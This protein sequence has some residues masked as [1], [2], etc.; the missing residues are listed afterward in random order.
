MKVYDSVVIG[1]GPAGLSAAIYLGRFNRKVAVIDSCE[2]R[3][4]SREINENYL[5]FPDGIPA[6]ALVFRGRQQ[7]EKFGAEFIESQVD[8]IE[9]QDELFK[10]SLT[11]NEVY[12][13][14][15]VLFAM[16]VEDIWPE[17]EYMRDCIGRSLFWCITCDGYKVR[18][19]RVAIIGNT[20]EAVTTCL[21]FLEYTKK[22]VFITNTHEQYSGVSFERRKLLQKYSVPFYQT[23]IA[24]VESQNGYMEKI[25]LD[26][27]ETIN[28]DFM[29]NQQGAKPRSELAKNAGVK[30]NE[31]GY[32][33]VD[34]EQRTTIKGM[35]AAG[36][37]TEMFAHQI[38]T[39]AHEGAQAA[40]A[41]NYD[42]Y[43]NDQRD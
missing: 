11:T 43:S 39:A 13:S 12:F 6:R 2:G 19:S 42:L 33:L 30:V 17:F 4:Q 31:M 21:Q 27:G 14:K 16:G 32:I 9:K 36:D 35:Y 1:G 34:R 29:F 41:I 22:L 24:T 15:T 28:V 7:A 8:S 10:L 5:G 20:D 40:Q 25:H 3:W 37:I 18:D 38:I 23:E 26:T